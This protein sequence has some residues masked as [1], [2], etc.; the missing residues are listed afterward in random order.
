MAD[1]V[2]GLL[3]MAYLANHT[4]K[5]WTDGTNAYAPG[6][7]IPANTYEAGETITLTAVFEENEATGDGESEYYFTLK[8]GESKYF[9][10]LP[11]SV[12]YEIW[13]MTET[14]WSLVSSSGATGTIQPNEMAAA[15]F[16]NRY[17]PAAASATINATK[18]LD[19]ER[20]DN[21]KFSFTLHQ[22]SGPET[23]ADMTKKNTSSGAVS[24]G[25]IKYS[26]EGTYVYEISEVEPGENFSHDGHTETVTV[27]VA[28]NTATG[29]MEAHVEY[30]SDGAV[31]NN[32]TKPAALTVTK[33]VTDDEETQLNAEGR[34]FT[35]KVTLT[36]LYDQ[37]LTTGFAKSA[38]GDLVPYVEI[39][40]EKTEITTG[41]ATFKLKA[42]ETATIGNIPEN[43]KYTVEETSLPAG[44]RTVGESTAA[45]KTAANKAYAVTVTNT[46]LPGS[47]SGTFVSFTAY[48][49][50]VG[51]TLLKDMFSFTLRQVSGPGYEDFVPE[52]VKNDSLIADEENEYYNKY[53]TVRFS[54][55]VYTVAGVYVYEITEN[56]GD[57]DNIAYDGHTLRYT[58]TVTD[59]GEGN[60]NAEI[61]REGEI[62]FTNRMLTGSLKVSKTVE[63]ATTLAAEREFTFTLNFADS[64]GAELGEE[65][66]LTITRL[67]GNEETGTVRSGGT[68][69]IKGGESFTVDG[70]PHQSRYTVTESAAKGFNCTSITGESTDLEKSTA[71]GTITAGS[72]AEVSYVNTYSTIGTA[73][74]SLRKIF[75]GGDIQREQFMFEL[76]ERTVETVTDDEGN[77]QEVVTWTVIDTGYANPDGT[78]GFS[79][80]D[81]TNEDDGKT[82]EYWVFEIDMGDENI[83]YDPEPIKISVEVHDNGE[84]EMTA[85]VTYDEA[86]PRQGTFTNY[87]LSDLTISKAAYGLVADGTFEFTISFTDEEGNEY[88]PAVPETWTETESGYTFTLRNGESTSVKLISGASY[89][90]VEAAGD[91][92]QTWVLNA[93]GN[94]TH[95]NGGT[96]ES[97]IDG[98]EDVI[99]INSMYELTVAKTATGAED[100]IANAEFA[101]TAAFYFGEATYELTELPEGWTKN[102]DGTYGF[103]LKNNGSV[104][105]KLPRGVRYEITEIDPDNNYT[106]SYVVTL[107]DGTVAETVN[108]ATASRTIGTNGNETVTFHNLQ[109]LKLEIA[110]E[111]TANADDVRS[112]W[113]TFI[114]SFE[115]NGATYELKEIPDGWTAV[116]GETGVYTFRLR[117]GESMSVK[118]PY[119]AKYKVTEL[120]PDGNHIT[121]YVIS[122]EEDEIESFEGNTAERTI[123]GS[124]NETILAKNHKLYE[125]EIAKR[126]DKKA[127]ELNIPNVIVCGNISAGL[128]PITDTES[129]FIDDTQAQIDYIINNYPKYE[130]IT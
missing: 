16:N 100:D 101:F 11:A 67:D 84:G 7:T 70:L 31:F 3:P 6:G 108:G 38:E 112:E 128:K 10:D 120:D 62:V 85:T 93:R 119:G 56:E 30:D 19:G 126:V 9:Y 36:D 51:E 104:K 2:S 42:G 124:G 73:E 96:V 57:N 29:A 64:T 127:I 1:E 95:G 82:F 32:Y 41:T 15:V 54:D 71:E 116:E 66:A 52:T 46:Y 23:I 63:N 18:Y 53:A 107:D 68:V 125:L 80:L 78:I 98:P 123:G 59:D 39:N 48:K 99:F 65:Y 75:K 94:E 97:T 44:W 12:Q 77:A 50:L 43:T 122:N 28:T 74:A 37:P 114:V 60:L 121:S 86:D 58:V 92:L 25:P 88:H 21:G 22:I 17:D 118:I 89:K 90:L 106:K 5:S 110:K 33:Q 61:E 49:E 26:V 34:E 47:V 8:G 14:G 24:F 4:L 40:G 109:M 27:Y 115:F 105:I 20:A 130:G 91:Y 69:S 55:I 72:E 45:G 103:K 76:R 83:T 102:D 129:N 113:F 35:F 117:S 13:E 87:G 79:A 81:F 111:L